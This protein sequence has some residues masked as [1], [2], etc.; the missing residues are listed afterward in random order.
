MM[1]E[2]HNKHGRGS[3]MILSLNAALLIGV[4]LMLPLAPVKA[5]AAETTISVQDKNGFVPLAKVTVFNENNGQQLANGLTD[6][7]TG[8]FTFRSPKGIGLIVAVH[9]STGYL[10]AA[11]V[12]SGDS[13]VVI[14]LQ[15]ATA[16][17]TIGRFVP[18]ST[19]MPG[20]SNGQNVCNPCSGFLNSSQQG[21]VVQTPGSSSGPGGNFGDTLGLSG[22]RSFYIDLP[23][24]ADGSGDSSKA[25]IA[26]VVWDTFEQIARGHSDKNGHFTFDIPEGMESDAFLIVRWTEAAQISLMPALPNNS[27]DRGVALGLGGQLG[28]FL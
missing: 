10:G 1:H 20:S 3:L 8:R 4:G 12:T 19:T 21:A 14:G 23:V 24:V 11:R 15:N 6:S 13:I 5:A 28:F 26:I 27:P 9:T 22:V 16:V 17:Q 7:G 25:M 2:R 18:G